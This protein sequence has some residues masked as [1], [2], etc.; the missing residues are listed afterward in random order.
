MIRKLL[1][2]FLLSAVIGAYNNKLHAQSDQEVARDLVAIAD[3]IFNVT[4]A[5]IDARDQY[6]QAADLDPTN[7]RAN[8][9]AGKLYLETINKERATKY[10]LQVLNLDPSY[11][12]DILYLIGRG[13][14]YGNDFEN[15]LEYYE[16]Y[17]NKLDKEVNYR[18]QDKIPHKEVE[19][20]IFECRNGIEFRAN[21]S[22]VSIVNVGRDVN[23]E[24]DDFAP[25]LNEDETLMI[26][27]T[28]RKDGN[29][30]EDVDLDNFAFEDIFS[31]T[32]TGG[33]W[34]KAQ[35]LGPTVNTKFHDSN[36]ALSR[37][38]KTLYLYKDD[39]GGDIYFSNQLAN[40]TW[41]K[42][43]ALSESIN[44]SF[45]ELSISIS[46]D[47]NTMF[48]SSN[49]PGG[50]GGIDIFMCTKD[51]RGKWGKS[52]NLGP[53]INT[54]YDEESP[55]IDYD[56]KTL[57]F[58][59]KGRKG[60]GQYDIFKSVYDSAER[61]WSEPLNLGFP[62]NTPDDDVFFVS[63]KDGKRGYY[64]SV[65]EDGMGYL[66]IYM[67]TI[68]D[69]NAPKEMLAS[70][71]NMQREKP[72]I[73]KDVTRV[74]QPEPTVKESAIKP[75]TLIVRIEDMNGSQPLD[76]KVSLVSDQSKISIPFKKLEK[77]VY[78]FTLSNPSDEEFML[79]SEKDGY[80]FKNF[81]ILVPA[82]SE[83]AREIKRKV[84]MDKLQV[85]LNTVLRNIYFDFNKS[86]FTMNSY[87]ELNKLEK[88]L[89]D[90]PGMKVEIAGHT[91]RVGTKE[92]NH[93]LSKK[94]ANAVV[95]YLTNKGIDA[96]RLNSKG[97]GQD[98]PLASNDDEK[99][100]R[101]LNR[102]VEFKVLSQR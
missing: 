5:Y 27:T 49:R 91:D 7:I 35:N 64:A 92:Y 100:G 20:R 98:R 62:I 32:K 87:A 50:Y 4:K 90:N 37:D 75:T 43:Q 71:E 1:L 73:N 2:L 48:F 66:D 12:F 74:I 8:Y 45:A 82:A 101:A 69:L 80:M 102:R 72:E 23:S 94:R 59:S 89:S 39:N 29:L 79:A 68:P 51:D 11:R 41:S 67:V 38:G 61:T 15:A 25:V 21:P 24:W 16:R 96:R 83:Q 63:T 9:M 42:P 86:S 19:R 52:V 10:Y 36:L 55:F 93:D 99:E 57:Y 65:R 60:M 97:Y 95:N 22:H 54:E 56:G 88:M 18:G 31:S 81:R 17:L 6:A 77:G 84:E 34:N 44:S 58:S 33:K 70:K 28:K 46:P 30:N 14:Q 26:F 40:G 76:A 13:Y 78:Q 85:G 47:N 53:N 3:E